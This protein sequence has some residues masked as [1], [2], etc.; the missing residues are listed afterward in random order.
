[1]ALHPSENRG[2][3]EAY[4]FGRAVADHWPNVAEHLPAE[5]AKAY[6]AGAEAAE[7]MVE[8][9][10][11]LTEPYGL[12]G[13]PA[14]QGLG[15]GIGRTRGSV[16]DRF[17]E[18]DRVARFALSEMSYLTTLLAFLQ[19]VADSR[20]DEPMSEFC[21]RWERKLKRAENSARKAA[22]GLGADPD[23]A[24]QPFD[25]SPTGRA[26][27]SVGYAIGAVGEWVDRQAGKRSG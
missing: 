14:A 27:H 25:T 26:A 6:R 3:R 10:G 23:R 8:E 15:R 24:V 18:T 5:A 16:R 9:L 12:Y 21:G 11:P 20:G 17:L 13:K 4:A 7:Q 1:M 19:Q 2:Y 22:A